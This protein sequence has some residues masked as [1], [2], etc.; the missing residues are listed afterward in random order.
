MSSQGA[1]ESPQRVPREFP[2]SFL[3]AKMEFGDAQ[4]TSPEAL[5]SLE[6][7]LKMKHS[8]VHKII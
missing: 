8:Y 2:R 1:A 6:N 3:G 5:K 7:D 4:K